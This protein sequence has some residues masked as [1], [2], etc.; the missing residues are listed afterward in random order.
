MYC[1]HSNIITTIPNPSAFQLEFLVL[2]S[3]LGAHFSY[4]VW[5]VKLNIVQENIVILVTHKPWES[6]NWPCEYWGS[7]KKCE[8]EYLLLTRDFKSQTL[9]YI[10]C[11]PRWRKESW[12]ELTQ[13]EIQ[14]VRKRGLWYGDWT[15][16][17]VIS[18]QPYCSIALKG[19]IERIDPGV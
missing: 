18:R 9:Q 2:H 13:N 19:L 6:V 14:T 16:F 12:L 4:K 3:Y 15:Y 11:R 8:R 5:S 1:K 10:C 7:R 17:P